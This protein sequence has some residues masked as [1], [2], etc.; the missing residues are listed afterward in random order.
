VGGAPKNRQQILKRE[1]KMKA[2][3]VSAI[4]SLQ[5]AQTQIDSGVNGLSGRVD[6]SVFD[7]LFDFMKNESDGTVAGLIQK[8]TAL[9]AQ[10]PD[11]V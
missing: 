9:V 8:L 7:P 1:N 5:N 2:Q 4:A 3:L 6:G 11:G 10:I